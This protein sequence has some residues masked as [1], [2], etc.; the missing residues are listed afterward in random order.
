MLPYWERAAYLNE[1]Q[2]LLRGDGHLGEI[3]HSLS[4][5][6]PAS[7][8]IIG[9]CSVLR[10][11]KHRD[12]DESDEGP[13][14]SHPRATSIFR[15]ATSPVAQVQNPRRTRSR[16][17]QYLHYTVQCSRNLLDENRIP[18]GV[19]LL[20]RARLPRPFPIIAL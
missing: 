15:G 16:C 6:R 1:Y 12:D 13:T 3:Q 10:A 14:Y 4:Y 2:L 9:T 18:A 5:L 20:I 7:K 17:R 11:P 19:F 8:V